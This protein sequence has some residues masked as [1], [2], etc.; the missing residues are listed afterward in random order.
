MTSSFHKLN[1]SHYRQKQEQ[2]Q[3]SQSV[4]FWS[5]KN[6]TAVRPV[7]LI[8]TVNISVGV[9]IPGGLSP[10]TQNTSLLSKPIYPLTVLL[11]WLYVEL[12]PRTGFKIV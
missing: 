12:S 1:P 9:L 8:L 7:N 2:K 11:G 6:S 5:T 10:I 4:F 3:F